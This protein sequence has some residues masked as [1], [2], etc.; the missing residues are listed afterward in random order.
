MLKRLTKYLALWVIGVPMVMAGIYYAFFAADRYV[1][2]SIVAVQQSGDTAVASVSGISTLLT[3]GNPEARAETLYLQEYIHSLDMLNYLD[4]KLGLRKAY[5]GEKLDFVYRLYEGTS[6]E[7]FLWYFRNR[8]EVSFD[9]VTGLLTIRTEGFDSALAHAINAEIL[10]QSEA[11][12]NEISHSMARDQ[13]V[14]ADGEL[15]KASDRLR[16]AKAQLLTFQNK[17]GVF[18]PLVQAQTTATLT[19]QFDAQIATKEAE[20][21]AKLGFMQDDAPSVINLRNEISALKAQAKT[22]QSKIAS[23]Q[24]GGKL[25]QLAAEFQNLTLEAGFA[26]EAYKAAL[27]AVETTR[28]EAS[29]KLKSLVVVESPSRPGTAIY[30]QRLYNLVTLVVVL[31]L[32]YGISR[33]V[34]ATIQDHQD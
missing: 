1:S 11:F 7:W 29:R 27:Q 19:S 16:V 30:P 32:L 31:L 17:Y 18:D 2:E 10:A 6:Q 33:L 20:L 25:N 8:V 26:E 15:R 13:M 4:A 28:I 22:E 24:G 23:S 14:F 5:E 3:G 34:I 12:V 9:D 21:K